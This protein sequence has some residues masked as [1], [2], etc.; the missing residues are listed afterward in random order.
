MKWIALI[1]TVLLVFLQPGHAQ[2]YKNEKLIYFDENGAKTKEK[3]A[4]ALEQVIKFNDTLYLF[5]FY[6]IDGPMFRS[7]STNDP[8]GNIVN[9]VYR[10]Y[11]ATGQMDST[12]L[13]HA[14]KRSGDWAVYSK[15]LY[16]QKLLYDDGKLLWAKDTLQLKHEGD[17]LA[18]NHKKDTSG[19]KVFTKV[20]IES[21]FPGA[22]KAWL[23]YLQANMHYPDKAV[24]KHIEGKVVIAFVVDKQGHI[25]MGRVYVDHSVEYMLDQEALRIIFVSPDW[26]PAVENGRVVNSYKKQPIVFRFR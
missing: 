21:S 1:V 22:A 7:F 5:N 26:T 25:P 15:G 16:S 4:A 24:K 18:A 20:E 17:S 6:R 2:A 8:N 14:G 13:C 10:S 9:G 19:D 3:N 23:N 11:D 12:G